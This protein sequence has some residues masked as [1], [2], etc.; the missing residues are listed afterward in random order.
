[1]CTNAQF[2]RMFL[3][4]EVQGY[5]KTSTVL[6]KILVKT[7]ADK[8]LADCPSDDHGLC[9][10]AETQQGPFLRCVVYLLRASR[11]NAR[12]Q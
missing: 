5:E 4:D 10:G 6:V 9:S 1:M 7:A 8:G 2:S 11:Y 3:S 12:F